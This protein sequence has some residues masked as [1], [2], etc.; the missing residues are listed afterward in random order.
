MSTFLNNLEKYSNNPKCH[1]IRG[2]QKVDEVRGLPGGGGLQ[3]V[4]LPQLLVAMMI[5]PVFIKLHLTA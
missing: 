1:K 3:A 2:Y 5:R 4:N